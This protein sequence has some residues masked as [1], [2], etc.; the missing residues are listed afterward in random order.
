ME[1]LFQYGVPTVLLFALVKWLK[2]HVDSML[3]AHGSLV[4]SLEK[5]VRQSD[6]N[7]RRLSRLMRDQAAS[8]RANTL[9][10]SCFESDVA[11][12]AH[13]SPPRVVLV[14]DSE[15][16]ALA[17]VGQV[18]AVLE[19]YG[20]DFTRVAA[21]SDAQQSDIAI[22]DLN[23]ADTMGLDTLHHIRRFCHGDVIVHSGAIDLETELVLKRLGWDYIH[24]GDRAGLTRC[25][26]KALRRWAV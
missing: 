15:V 5:S 8:H 26:E 1:Q 23:L 6:R 3:V 16:D 7:W 13:V 11:R 25:L 14:E 22:V 2:P 24:K 17:I 9:L 12:R 20:A 18:T 21:I 4:S 19:R 10:L